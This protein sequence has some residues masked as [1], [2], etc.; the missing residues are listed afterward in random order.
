MPAA[1]NNVVGIKPTVGLTSRH[2]VVPIS[3]SQDTVGPIARSVKDAA[4][5]LQV[6]AGSDSSDAHTLAAPTMIPNYIA[7]CK[8]GSLRGKRIGIA[9]NVT[10]ISKNEFSHM[11]DAFEK[12]IVIMRSAGAIIIED[13]DFTAYAEVTTRGFNPVPRSEFLHDLPNYLKNLEWNPNG[14]TDL[15]SLRD[16]VRAHPQ[17]NFP[18]RD[19]QSWDSVLEKDVN[20]SSDEFKAWYARNLYL[21]GEGGVLGALERHNLDAVV[22]PT[23]LASAG[24]PAI[25]GTPIVN[26]PLGKA[27]SDMPVVLEEHY[28]NAVETAPGLP[29]GISFLGRKW[30][31]DK[32]IGM[33]YALEQRMPLSGTLPRCVEPQADLESTMKLTSSAMALGLSLASE[34]TAVLAQQASID[35]AL[36]SHAHVEGEHIA[37]SL[38]A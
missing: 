33:A 35:A 11:M 27:S 4:L 24:V 32:L 5:L 22:L 28:R 20:I 23:C 12:A 19:T 18:I 6:M 21:G 3:R 34:L 1:R 7:A 31:E 30:S 2:L 37:S 25:V 36:H 38:V 14:I 13:T 17:E 10:Q 15:K 16:F 26:I 29:F 9:R 8:M